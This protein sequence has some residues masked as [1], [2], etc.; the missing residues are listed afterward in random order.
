MRRHRKCRL[1]AFRWRNKLRLLLEEHSPL[2]R[3]RRRKEASGLSGYGRTGSSIPYAVLRQLLLRKCL[4]ERRLNLRSYDSD[5]V[6]GWNHLLRAKIS[7][8]RRT[9]PAIHWNH[10]PS[11][12]QILHF[13]HFLPLPE[14][15]RQH[16]HRI[17]FH[18]FHFREYFAANYSYQYLLGWFSRFSRTHELSYQSDGCKGKCQDKS[19]SHFSHWRSYWH[20][21]VRKRLRCIQNSAGRPT[22][23]LTFPTRLWLPGFSTDVPE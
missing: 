3:V 23:V 15:P 6:L 12:H 2:L 14:S 5:S 21:D 9:Q 4:Q 13:P 22:V 18:Q 19:A 7:L 16:L 17:S 8:Y 11:S 20:S 1:L 10:K